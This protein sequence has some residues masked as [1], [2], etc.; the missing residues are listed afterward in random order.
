M[1]AELERA[2][3]AAH[4]ALV[5]IGDA[6]AGDTYR[7][8]YVGNRAISPH[9]RDLAARTL[10][11]AKQA[12]RWPLEMPLEINWIVPEGRAVASGMPVAG[13]YGSIIPINGSTDGYSG[14]NVDGTLGDRDLVKT[15]AHEVLHCS[16]PA[17][18][19]EK[20]YEYAEFFAKTYY[21]SGQLR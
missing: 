10:H 7:Y 17:M 9:S 1:S 5:A 16:N 13:R 12:F 6:V 2:R 11:L 19:H 20:V 21:D 8:R 4:D 15:V 18:A 14:I 3:R